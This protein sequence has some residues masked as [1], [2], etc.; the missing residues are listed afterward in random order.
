LRQVRTRLTGLALAFGAVIFGAGYFGA[1]S[2]SPAAAQTASLNLYGMPGLIDMP[3]GEAAPDAQ[4]SITAGSFGGMTRNTLS[5]QIT[6]RL[7]G[8][9]RYAILQNCNCFR[10]ST[11]YD[12]S[13][14]VQYQITHEGRYRPAISVGLRD[15]IGTG[16]YSSEYFAA[17][18]HLTPTLRLTGGIGWGRLGSYN[19]FKNPLGLTKR[20]KFKGGTGGTLLGQWFRGPAALFA[21]VEWQTRRP[22]LSLKAEYSSDALAFETKNGL[23]TPRWPFNFGLDYQLTQTTHLSGTYMYGARL[24]LR[25]T[26][27][28]NPGRKPV[29][30]SLESAPL[31]VY[32]RP[33][34]RE[35]GAEL[36]ADTTW[37]TQPGA[38]KILLENLQTLA[39][40]DGFTIETLSLTAQSA[41]VR[42]RNGTYDA[43]PQAIG[44]MARVMSR[45]LPPSVETFVLTPVER[46]L[47]VV[48]VTLKR[49]DLE[50][51]E[52]TPDGT[53]LSLDRALISDAAPLRGPRVGANLYPGTSW[54]LGPYLRYSLFDP[55]SP[56]RADIGV[57][58]Q[59]R[60]EVSRGLSISGS[61]IKK[62]VGN[63]NT[64][65]RLSNSLLPHV[66]SDFGLYDKQADPAL[67]YLYGNYMFRPGRNLYGRVSV[68]YLEKMYGGI[69]AEVLW[70]PVN[71]RIAIGLEANI[72]RQRAFNMGFGFQSYQIATGHVSGYWEMKN[73]FST[74]VDVGRYLAGDYG[75]TLTVQRRFTNGWKVGAFMTL[76]NV[77][78]KKFGEGSFDKGLTFTIPLSWSLGRP[79]K[80]ASTTVI[81]PTTRD[82][83]ARL[84]ISDRL[85]PIVNRY[86][87]NPLTNNWGRFWR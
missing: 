5:F 42:F 16:I 12:R 6:P 68:G 41:E 19:S 39:G 10:F 28:L 21:G 79:N 46:G 83:G 75:A 82:G 55:D 80:Q 76:T 22:G 70:K 63:L 49:R 85:Y 69:S 25:L 43:A 18:K 8:A 52:N 78:A 60:L 13:F 50:D 1:G 35:Q 11:Y 51:L 15:L 7:T 45:I 71:R 40:N 37:T 57:R 4:F 81:R 20:P 58:A 84:A 53:A 33:R 44:R 61:V 74:Q 24:G 72:V 67:E 30:G 87:R 36:T 65:T 64:I 48:T 73:G 14:D 86:H 9:F 29:T 23:F 56:V 26:F 38:Q 34:D 59:G 27:A 32:R 31:P 3:S 2:F 54:M 62:V 47:P 77:S 66:R 17:T